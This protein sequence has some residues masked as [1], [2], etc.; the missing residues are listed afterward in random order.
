MDKGG[1]HMVPGG[2][3]GWGYGKPREMCGLG[4]AFW[5][6][7]FVWPWSLPQGHAYS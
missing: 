7:Q 5:S 1:G 3:K 2:T 6:L 4:S